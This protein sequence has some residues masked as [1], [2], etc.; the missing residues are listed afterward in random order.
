MFNTFI[1]YL[2]IMALNSDSNI[3][4]GQ[5]IEI[6][7]TFRNEKSRPMRVK[8]RNNRVIITEEQ[9][10]IETSMSENRAN[11]VNQSHVDDRNLVQI[12]VSNENSCEK[13]KVAIYNSR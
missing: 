4:I 5:P 1:V 13:S 11:R 3:S 7:T 10:N 6:R 8:N 2:I 12:N 9:S